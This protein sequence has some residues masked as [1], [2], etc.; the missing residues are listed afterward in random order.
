MKRILLSVVMLMSVLTGSVFAAESAGEVLLKNVS[1][2]RDSVLAELGATKGEEML[3]QVVVQQKLFNAAK[4]E[5]DLEEAARVTPFGHVEAHMLNTLAYRLI[6]SINDG[7][8]TDVSGDLSKARN[9][10]DQASD[11]SKA[12]RAA[13]YRTATKTAEDVVASLDEVD[14]YITKNTIWVECKQDPSM[15]PKK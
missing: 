10:L 1:G 8:S 15:C 3:K 2:H 5:G 12:A 13:S 6:L 4:K 7:N 14:G 11:A 9:Y